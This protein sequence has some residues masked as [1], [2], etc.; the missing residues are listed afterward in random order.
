LAA[1]KKMV[2]RN[3]YDLEDVAKIVNAHNNATLT[4]EFT[5]KAPST[6]II[7]MITNE[8]NQYDLVLK[9]IEQTKK[10]DCAKNNQTF[11]GLLN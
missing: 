4:D 1:Q 3:W 6:I 11:V 10:W 7:N 5:R 8:V 2:W 9:Q